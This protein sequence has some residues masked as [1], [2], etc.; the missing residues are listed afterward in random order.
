MASTRRCPP[1][2]LRATRDDA[3]LTARVPPIWRNE[4]SSHHR[5]NDLLRPCE[6]LNSYARR[7]WAPD[8]Q[9]DPVARLAGADRHSF[10]RVDRGRLVCRA[11]RGRRPRRQDRSFNAAVKEPMWCASHCTDA[12]AHRRSGRD[13]HA[14]AAVSAPCATPRNRVDSDAPDAASVLR[15]FVMAVCRSPHPPAAPQRIKSNPCQSSI[16]ILACSVLFAVR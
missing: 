6:I 15:R 10:R 13:R 2:H 12:G 7:R 3:T 9:R 1:G 5:L 16:T 11:S 14:G 8:L 4:A